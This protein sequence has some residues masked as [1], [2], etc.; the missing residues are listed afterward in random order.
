MSKVGGR[1]G[2]EMQYLINKQTVQNKTIGGGKIVD[3]HH[4]VIKIPHTESG[5]TRTQLWT[6][7]QG[8][9]GRRMRL[10]Y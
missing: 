2:N 4:S 8:Q 3:Q 9:N 1:K 7:G 10:E 6:K 5:D